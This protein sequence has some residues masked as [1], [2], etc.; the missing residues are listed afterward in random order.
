MG[1]VRGVDD[2]VEWKCRQISFVPDVVEPERA[3]EVQFDVGTAHEVHLDSGCP[4]EHRRQESDGARPEHQRSIAF[5]QIGGLSG[6]ERV[7]SRL[8]EC[9][10][11]V[12]NGVGQLMK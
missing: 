10:E 5:A 7:R 3:S 11:R 8:D 12:I 4:D 9:S 6:T 1:G 2:G